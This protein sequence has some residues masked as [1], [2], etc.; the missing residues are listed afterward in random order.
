MG[1]GWYA[2]RLRAM[3]P[4]EVA[5]RLQQALRR[6]ARRL[7]AGR[8]TADPALDGRPSGAHS[9]RFFNL[10]WSFPSPEPIDWSRDYQN[11]LAAPRVFYGD[12]DYRD[13]RQVGD[14]KYTW[15]LNRHQFLAPW[16]VA[17]RGTGDEDH[18]AAVVALILDWIRA[19]PRYLGINWISA[20]EMALRILSWGIA[21][22]LCAASPHVR[23]ARGTIAASVADQAGFIRRSLSRFSSA[24]N[25]LVGELVGLLATA[26]FFPEVAGARSLASFAAREITREALRQTFPDGVNREQAVYYHHYTLE[27]SLTAMALFARLGLEIPE[28]LGERVR[29][30]LAFVDAMTDDAGEAFEVGDRDDGTVTGLNLGTG[31]GVYESLLWSGW[32]VFR[33]EALGAHAA[34]IARHAGRPAAPDLRSGYWHARG[35]MPRLPEPGRRVVRRLFA[36][37]GYF[38]STDDGFSLLFKAGPFGYPSI[39]AH[40]HCDQL[41]VGLKRGLTTL[42]TDAGTFVYHTDE[43]WRRFFKGTSA[44]NTV[45]VDERDQAEFA[46]PF[47]WSSHADGRM[48]LRVEAPGRFLVW[49]THDGYRRLADPVAHERTVEYRRGRGY[50]VADRLTGRE[51]HRFALFWN[52]G[53]GLALRPLGSGS[54]SARAW[55]VLE[56]GEPVMAVRIESDRPLRFDTCEGDEKLPAGF[57]SRR[58]LE[59]R[60]IVRLR[61]HAEGPSC[62]FVSLLMTAGPPGDAALV[63]RM[64]EEWD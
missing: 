46:G 25:H 50:R 58:Y 22:E 9:V 17:Y 15:E 31:V 8:A 7:R 23:Q 52:F 44:H 29:R 11:D 63:E 53:A 48:E 38:L 28:E 10:A 4:V 13:F 55:L 21:L 40:A 19:N 37:G 12:L 36:D 47:L 3:S 32:L 43:R 18:A 34:R 51:A 62:R 14:S 5:H 20:L 49:G 26:A 2:A 60:P 57:E 64:A 35:E 54:A 24:N 27:Y 56:G 39:A 30:M 45:G 41:S 33:D 42:L 1:L 59:K 16:A 6:E 61:A